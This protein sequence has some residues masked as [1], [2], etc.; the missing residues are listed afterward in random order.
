MTDEN[1]RFRR[2]WAP[3]PHDSRIERIEHEVRVVIAAGGRSA[4]R[5]RL[6]PLLR[7]AVVERPQDDDGDGHQESPAVTT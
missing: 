5:A 2:R 4:L 1:M 6:L 3:N 7:E